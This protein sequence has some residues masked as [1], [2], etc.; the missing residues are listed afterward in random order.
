MAGIGGTLIGREADV[1]WLGAVVAAAAA[2]TPSAAIVRGE[3]GIGKSS[4]VAAALDSVDAAILTATGDEGEIDVDYGI[5][6]QLLDGAARAGA[7]DL[8]RHGRRGWKTI[9][10]ECIT[11]A[12]P[13]STD[14]CRAAGSATPRRSWPS[15]TSLHPQATPRS[16]LM[17]PGRRG[18]S[19]PQKVTTPP[20][21]T[22]SLAG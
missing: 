18:C 8:R 17:L 9:P 10:K 16:P 14:W 22:P 2:G 5:V 13:T 21:A 12:L 19:P 6:D 15:S 11:G 4:L 1:A 7:S 20:P 3:A